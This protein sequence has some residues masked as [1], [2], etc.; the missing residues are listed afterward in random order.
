MKIQ[1][2]TIPFFLILFIVMPIYAQ[3]IFI[4]EIMSSN[5]SIIA[6]EDADYSDWIELY[7]AE[8]RTANLKNFGLSDDESSLFKWVFPEIRVAPHQFLLIFASGKDIKKIPIH[9]ETIID[10]GDEWRYLVPTA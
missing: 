5:V 8:S 7:N 2:T 9:W 6:D 1:Q 4:N 3:N 10:M